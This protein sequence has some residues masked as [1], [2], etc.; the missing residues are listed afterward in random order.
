M[1]NYT[2]LSQDILYCFSVG[3][4]AILEKDSVGIQHFKYIEKPCAP[5]QPVFQL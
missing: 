2:T 4:K 3:I 5:K 1:K